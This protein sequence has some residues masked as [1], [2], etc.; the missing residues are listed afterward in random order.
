MIPMGYGADGL[1]ICLPGRVPV[2]G[3]DCVVEG[4]YFVAESSIVV[5]FAVG[6]LAICLIFKLLK[7]PM[8]LMLK[9]I[10]NSICGAI[11]LFLFN[12]FGADIKITVINALIAGVFGVPGVIG[13]FIW[14]NFIAG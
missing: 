6:L 9:F 14:E 11:I 4:G 7:W 2:P 3:Q 1:M 8:E 5:S 10:S 13:L 12:L